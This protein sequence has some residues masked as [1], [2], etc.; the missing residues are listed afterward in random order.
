MEL[1]ERQ[2]QLTQLERNLRA[3]AG[4]CGKALLIGGEAGVGKSSLVEA[5][6]GDQGNDV[7]V[8][9]GNCD[10]LSTPRVL[11]PVY[12][13]AA[14]M[15]ALDGLRGEPSRERLFA[16]LFEELAG[17]PVTIIVLEDIHWADEA[18]LDFV[19]FIVRRIQ[20]TRCLFL[21]T[22]RD[23]EISAAHPLRRTLGDLTGN[24]I[25][26]LSLA[27]LSESSV[28]KLAHDSGRDATD[29]YSITGGNPF[30]VR[31]L[32]S[33]SGEAVPET[34]RDAVLARVAR[35]SEPAR[36][37]AE[38][39]SLLPGKTELWLLESLLATEGVIDAVE[40]GLLRHLGDALAF[41][42]ELARLAV[43][44]GL[45]PAQ[46][47]QMHRRILHAL[48]ARG[49]D[50][51]RLVHHAERS[52]QVAEILEY[53][54]RAGREAAALGAHREAAEHYAMALRY[55][56]RLPPERRAELLDRHAWECYVTNRIELTVASA[57]AALALWRELGNAL[58]E[59]RTLLVLSRQHWKLGNKAAADRYVAEAID[60]LE[61]QPEQ[62][63][64]GMAYS[65]R[66]QLD[67]LEGR[68]ESAMSYG[69]RAIALARKFG[70]PET[71]SHALNNVGTSL[72][73]SG[74]D[75]GY[76]M[77]ELSLEIARKYRLHEHAGRAYANLSTCSIWRH[78]F[79]RAKKYLEEGIAYCEEHENFTNLAYLRAYLARFELERGR[80]E[81]AADVA[82]SLLRNPEINAVQRIPALV[83]LALVR[84]RRGDPAAEPLLDEAEDLANRTGELQRIGRVAAARAE[85]A[86]YRGETEPGLRYLSVAID[87]AEGHHD[88]WIEGELLYWRS[89]FAT[90]DRAPEQIAEPYRL[91]ID[92]EWRSAAN[93]WKDIGMPYEEALA[94]SLGPEAALRQALDILETLQAGPLAAMVRRRLRELGAHNIPRGP[95]STTR[96]NPAGLTNREIEV[97]ELLVDGHSN[98]DLARRLHVSVKT[99]G[100]HVSSILA[101][102]EVRT[103]TEAATAAL[104]L[105][106]VRPPSK[107]HN[108]TH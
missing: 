79:P 48:Q 16:G 31:E 91:M 30:F 90:V 45:H 34:V 20:R 43:E 51:S 17:R 18:T 42:H 63:E 95:R 61:R 36:A 38:F 50:L 19:A 40:G 70:D 58:A 75:A 68:V 101:K 11:G 3:V 104:R 53:A 32:L 62:L 2:T 108:L 23:D 60:L 102:L 8:L 71:E 14:R 72:I 86:W 66:S 41:R 52:G 57:E 76:E 55:G 98:A 15:P 33:A 89:R 29:I 47:E 81:E 46:A 35:C 25:A 5:F 4:G 59:S 64:L 80:W 26:R 22:F 107:T 1:L 93:A 85:L 9:W 24:H 78:D 28:A 84:V 96:Q 69:H 83:A 106:I 12:E 6:V 99:A 73:T 67:M 103:R 56:D 27:P 94:L 44:S 77:V 13:V 65:A 100:H 10:A 54:P 74:D 92:G 39:V 37:V 49:A 97:L 82:T 87:L 21:A 105:G 88:A 7:R